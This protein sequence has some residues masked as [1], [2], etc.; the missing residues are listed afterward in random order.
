MLCA[1]A[2]LY[3]CH[4]GDLFAKKKIAERPEFDVVASRQAQG[5]PPKVEDPAVLAKVANLLGP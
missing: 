2:D 4:P 1:L 3:G 5:L